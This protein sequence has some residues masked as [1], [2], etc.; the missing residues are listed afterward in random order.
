MLLVTMLA[1]TT[2]FSGCGKKDVDYDMGEGGTEEG[3]TGDG[4]ELSSRLGVP[5]SYDGEI[6]VGDSGLDK[7]K[8]EDDDI[9][10]PASDSMSIVSYKKNTFDNAYK[11]KS[12]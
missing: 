8:I 5:E 3:G 11:Q 6:E 7:I 2:A 9:I 10:T 4:G 1:A 12:L